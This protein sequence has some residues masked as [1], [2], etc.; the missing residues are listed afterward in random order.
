MARHL[1]SRNAAMEEQRQQR[2]S[3]EMQ[4]EG[5]EGRQAQLCRRL[6]VSTVLHQAISSAHH[7]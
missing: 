6:L 5:L 3:S 7:M 4:Q 2:V 1:A